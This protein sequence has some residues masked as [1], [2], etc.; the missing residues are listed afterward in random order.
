MHCIRAAVLGRMFN[1]YLLSLFGRMEMWL[2]RT[3]QFYFETTNS[4]CVKWTLQMHSEQ[5]LFLF[6]PTN[7]DASDSG[8]WNQQKINRQSAHCIVFDLGDKRLINYNFSIHFILTSIVW[9]IFNITICLLLVFFIFFYHVLLFLLRF[10]RS[11]FLI[12]IRWMN[13]MAL[14][15]EK[16][17]FNA[18]CEREMKRKI[19]KKK[20]ILWQ[21][22]A[23]R[24]KS[25]Q[26]TRNKY[27]VAAEQWST[28]GRKKVSGLKW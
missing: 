18:K 27:V 22:K 13:F 14:N 17:S 15:A 6:Q 5:I 9:N 28:A 21:V 19:K 20:K 3:K 2:N 8:K 7:A 1:S 4:F 12:Y 25:V 26:M 24:S 11:Q 16:R 10:G 23:E